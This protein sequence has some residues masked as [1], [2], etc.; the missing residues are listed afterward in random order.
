LPVETIC[1]ALA[2]IAQQA[3]PQAQVFDTLPE[4]VGRLPAIL[5]YPGSGTVQ[6]P[7][8]PSTYVVEHTIE[9]RL[10]FSRSDAP[11][12]DA[13]ARPWIEKMRAAIDADRLLGGIAEDSG[14]TGYRYGVIEYGGVQYI[15]IVL[16]VRALERV[17]FPQPSYPT[18][19]SA[20]AGGA[21]TG[22]VTTSG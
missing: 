19:G 18:L 10:L 15:G 13:A 1:S 20:S 3:N 9:L 11:S 6:W 2:K 22:E 7:R 4:S 12:S 17:L 16:T 14:V 8:G 5:I 21:V